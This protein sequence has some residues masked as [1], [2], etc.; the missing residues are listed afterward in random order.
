MF[1]TERFVSLSC[2]RKQ[3]S[4]YIYTNQMQPFKLKIK[5]KSKVKL[6]TLT[7]QTAILVKHIHI[8]NS[9]KRVLT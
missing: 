9:M 2:Q 8:T 6:L 5:I 3:V 7:S 1:V 4:D